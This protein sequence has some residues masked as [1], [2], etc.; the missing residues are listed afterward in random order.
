[1]ITVSTAE[2]R[3]E[4][5]EFL[6]AHR[7]RLAPAAIGLPAGTRRRTPGLRREEVAQLCGLSATWYT[8]IEQGRDVSV[9][10]VALARLARALRL[11]RAER[12][13]LF[14]LA[15]KRDPDH[16][17]SEADQLPA[18][19][20][21]CVASIGCPAYIL[22]RGWNARCWN[23]EAE[24]LFVGW[25]DQPGT[26][27]LL[28]FIFTAPAARALICDWDMRARRVVAEFRAT[29]SAHLSD[30]ALRVLIEELRQKSRDFTRLWEA[31]DVLGR[32]GGE[33]TFNH[34]TEGFLRYEQVTFDLAGSPDFKLT[35]LVRRASAEVL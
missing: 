24:R 1:M 10:P 6:R 17:E 5:G 14:A 21:A 28:R 16:G 18:A 33:R 19:A 23:A 9:S 4:L 11:S 31:H 3:R 30:P 29:Y 8:W 27:N 2:E 25:L 7:E 13:Y 22:D 35:M 15:G 26:S 12:A 34:P 20:A 32:E